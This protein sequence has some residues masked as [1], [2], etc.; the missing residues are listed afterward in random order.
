M[1]GFLK[2]AEQK[3]L[4][5][6]PLIWSTRVHLVLYYGILYNLLLA[7]LSYL[8]PL[9]VL[10]DTNEE[11]WI[12]FQIIIAAIAGIIWLIYLLRFNVFKKYGT[13][14]P[15]H[16]LTT[17]LL[18][19]VSTGIIVLS[20][21]I[22]PVVESVRVNL[23]Y[24]DIVLVQDINNL[25]LKICQLEHQVLNR[26]WGYDTVAVVE[27][28]KS[29]GRIIEHEAIYKDTTPDGAPIWSHALV[30]MD[31]AT[32]N[33]TLAGIDSVVKLNDTMYLFYN[34]PRLQFMSGYMLAV[35]SK[36]KLLSSFDLY[37]RAL[38]HPPTE[39]A[40]HTI[41]KELNEL[42]RK[43]LGGKKAGTYGG[44]TQPDETPGDYILKHYPLV[45]INNNIT[46]ITSKKFD[47]S[48]RHL[49]EYIRLF[50][51]FTLG[52]TLLIFIFRH[53]TVQTFFLSLLVGVLLLILTTMILS[54]TNN[55]SAIMDWIV[56]YALLFFA[57]SIFTFSS[58]KRSVVNGI[59]INLFVFMAPVFPLLVFGM[60]Y[61]WNEKRY[62]AG[63]GNYEG[64]F[65]KQYLPYAEIAGPVLF[66]VLLATY[67]NKLYRRWYSL[68]EN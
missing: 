43:Y 65:L 51:Y 31:T 2:R 68:P 24:S 59:F 12:S 28:G 25:T 17:F 67:I 64:F 52:I 60:F 34:T 22:Y 19:F 33:S 61:E 30:A 16:A 3:L 45:D 37:N 58:T 54:F 11:Y 42:E 5:N 39:A 8:A 7:G 44:D 15:L 57:R 48:E 4:L 18:Y 40:M 47:F 53:T 20:V 36:E 10:G 56:C 41:A 9:D 50:Y 23:M 26:K 13:I 1:P 62:Y 38:K 63:H 49:A 29:G 6:K 27:N 21:F 66:L 35:Y 46:T 55:N 14:K 32:F